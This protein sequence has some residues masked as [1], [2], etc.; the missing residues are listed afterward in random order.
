MGFTICRIHKDYIDEDSS[1]LDILPA[2]WSTLRRNSQPYYTSACEPFVSFS[3]TLLSPN[4]WGGTY[5]GVGWQAMIKPF[6]ASYFILPNFG[7]HPVSLMAEVCR[8][9]PTE[10]GHSQCLFISG[11]CLSNKLPGEK[12]HFIHPCFILDRMIQQFKRSVRSAINQ[13]QN[14]MKSWLIQGGPMLAP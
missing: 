10:K 1:I 5:G 13:G 14:P 11:P 8:R 9:I 7:P 2:I 3:K 4:F 12:K 6:M